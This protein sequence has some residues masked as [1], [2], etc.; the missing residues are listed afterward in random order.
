[1]VPCG[2][3]LQGFF[4]SNHSGLNV[5]IQLLARHN[6]KQWIMK[7]IR[8][9]LI[10]AILVF[11]QCSN[12]QS[13]SDKMYNA[14]TDM[15]GVTNISFSKN[16]VDAVNINV[17][18]KGDE[19][20]VTGDLYRVRFMAYNP[21]KGDMSGSQFITK[22]V[23]MLPWQYMKFE[24]NDSDSNTEIWLLG[25][26]RKFRECHVFISNKSENQRQFV[27]S[28]YGD[29]TVNDIKSLKSNGMK[30]SE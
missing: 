28:F 2:F 9:L 10:A 7:S 26:K 21:E 20:K 11:S 1:M 27:V 22:A 29:F 8:I 12:G 16:M 13:K 3:W 5:M 24:D 15:D 30:I 19:Q 23:R 25:R 18:D 14:F 4:Y 17:G 6:S